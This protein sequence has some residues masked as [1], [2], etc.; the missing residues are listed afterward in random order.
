[1]ATTNKVEVSVD[2][3]KVILNQLFHYKFNLNSQVEADSAILADRGSSVD[4]DSILLNLDCNLT[5]INKIDKVVEELNELIQ[6]ED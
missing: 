1:M 6:E 3:V 2:T 4:Y 5:S